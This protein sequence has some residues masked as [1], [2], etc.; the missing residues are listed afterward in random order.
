[1][2]GDPLSDRFAKRQQK[3]KLR[4]LAKKARSK[5]D[6]EAEQ[7]LLKKTDKTEPI[8]AMGV[9]AP[10]AD[11]KKGVSLGTLFLYIPGE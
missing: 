2:N 3:D 5:E 7:E 6:V 9:A 1:M 11:A 4:E 10:P 8:K